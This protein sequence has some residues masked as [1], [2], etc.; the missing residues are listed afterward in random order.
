MSF[1]THRRGSGYLEIDGRRVEIKATGFKGV[2]EP[3]LRF[4]RTAVGLVRRLQANLAKSVPD[5][6]TVIV[7]ITAPIRQA[8]R[9]GA[10]I[11]DRIRSLFA[12]R[13]S[14]LK[15]LIYGNRVQVQVLK[16]RAS[17]TSKLI[18]FVHNPEPSP[19]L[20]FDVTRFLLA[21]LGSN[22]R[23]QRRDRWL[24]IANEDGCAP[25]ETLRQVCLA[26]TI[27]PPRSIAKRSARFLP[28]E[29]VH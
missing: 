7:T 14:R 19:A 28:T 12:T 18:G 11:E 10:A 21:H 23:P 22:T 2:K 20:L 26:L 13:R 16:G 9:T 17:R 25:I 6:K 27:P 4:D 8:S 3:R 5:G 29:V 24:G 1:G 15:A